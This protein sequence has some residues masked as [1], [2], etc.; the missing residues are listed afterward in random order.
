MQ[1]D[2]QT[3]RQTQRQTDRHRDRQIDTET[4]RQIQTY[5]YKDGQADVEVQTDG[6]AERI[7]ID[8]QATDRHTDRQTDRHSIVRIIKSLAYLSKKKN[9]ISCEYFSI[10]IFTP[11]LQ[12]RGITAT[13][14]FPR[15]PFQ[16]YNRLLN[17]TIRVC[18]LTVYR[19][20]EASRPIVDA[21][22]C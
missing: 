1:T 11:K 3:D 9:P 16:F 22:R 20:G 5:T 21:I 19:Y 4:D 12:G 18:R 6:Q 15:T 17:F 10:N 13:S 14:A 2:R 7:Q 8:R